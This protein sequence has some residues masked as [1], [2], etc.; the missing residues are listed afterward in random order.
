MKTVKGFFEGINHSDK[1]SGKGVTP[2][3]FW[4][5][6]KQMVKWLAVK[7]EPYAGTGESG[8]SNPT[9]SAK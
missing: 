1:E 9:N 7:A 4:Q 6:E 5:W 3:K 2:T 8:K